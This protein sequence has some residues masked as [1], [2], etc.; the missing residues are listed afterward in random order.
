MKIIN[1]ALLLF[2]S[3][4]S[5]ICFGSPIQG[6][7]AVK[8]I[9][10]SP[11]VCTISNGEEIRVNFGDNLGVNKIDGINYREEINYNL[12]CEENV[13]QLDLTLSIIGPATTYD[14][15]TL[16]TN[17][18]S[19][20]IKIYQDGLPFIIGSNLKINA[21]SPPKLEAIPIAKPGENL[22]EGDFF[23][24]ATIKANYQ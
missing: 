7:L 2:T 8:G 3:S 22:E 16:Q 12:V 1:L 21:Q 11:P 10:I 9:L 24:T 6:D 23:V 5:N 15:S 13:N 18:P 4:L 14:K 17:I 20:G 19:L